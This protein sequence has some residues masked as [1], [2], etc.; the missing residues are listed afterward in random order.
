MKRRNFILFIFFSIILAGSCTKL[1][2]NVGSNLT[3]GQ[4]SKDSSYAA[5][6]LQG[7]YA[8]L[9]L[10]FTNF[11]EIFALSELTTDEAIAP[12]R[13]NNWDDNGMW[14]VLHQQKYDPSNV[15]IHDCFNHLS[16]V[17]HAATD[18]LQYKPSP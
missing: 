1:N 12:T 16:G 4:V 10:T 5:I 3:Q 13:A 6:L 17:V 9:E 18:M 7:V 15:V 2:E 11:L 8:S 14:R